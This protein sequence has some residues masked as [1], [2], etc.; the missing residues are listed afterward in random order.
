MRAYPLA[1]FRN[2]PAPSPQES[3]TFKRLPY[4]LILFLAVPWIVASQQLSDKDKT[5]LQERL[6]PSRHSALP[7]VGELVRQQTESPEAQQRRQ[8]KEQWYRQWTDARDIKD[9]GLLVDGAT[10]TRY[11]T[12]INYAVPLSAE[13]LGLPA[14]SSSA[15]VVGSILSAECFVDELRTTVYTDYKVKIAQVLKDSTGALSVG[16]QIVASRAEGSVHFPSGHVTHYLTH[17]EGLPK[18][19]SDYVLFLFPVANLQGEY[20]ITT[21]YELK[22]GRVFALDDV[23]AQYSNLDQA[24]LLK[25]VATVIAQNGGAKP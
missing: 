2:E 6:R 19:N 17:G 9:P 12:F 21:G 23:N 7:V 1:I 11:V 8:S 16:S 5:T 3:F 24:A 22:N 10:E 20:R 15:V 13:P 18:I 25:Q 14:S 4:Y